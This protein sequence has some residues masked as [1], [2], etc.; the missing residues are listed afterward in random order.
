VRG[1]ITRMNEAELKTQEKSQ[2]EAV[3]GNA[4]AA[5]VPRGWNRGDRRCLI[6]WVAV[7]LALPALILWATH[8]TLQGKSALSIQD[9]LHAK[10]TTAFFIALATWVVASMQKRP[11]GDF[12]IPPRQAL[13]LRF[14]E[15]CVWGFGMLSALLLALWVPGYFR[16]GAVNLEVN[17]FARYALGWAVVFLCVS[18]S[19][20]FLFRGYLLFVTS[21]RAGFWRASVALSI[22]FAA[23]HLGNPGEN[24]LGI[25]QVFGTGLLFC[26]M[27]RRTGHLWFALGYHAAWDWAE[28]FFYGTADSGMLGIGRYLTTS[29]EGPKWITGGSVGPEGSAIALI[30][31]ALCA[32]LI[33][34]R[35]PRAIYPDYPK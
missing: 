26:F 9:E 31:L 23:A 20:E 19:E 18:I 30:V 21:R 11:L 4:P 24:V 28:T 10:G 29:A 7:G 15:G 13:G 34:L 5:G 2:A 17:A 25:L 12:G 27:I 33:H 6:L 1:I 3:T 35:F 22:G 16:I 8:G 32:L 14:W